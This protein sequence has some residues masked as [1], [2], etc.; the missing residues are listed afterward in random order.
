MIDVADI[1]TKISKAAGVLYALRDY[2]PE[3]SLRTLYYSI[4]YPHMS[5]H[6]LAWGKSP[7]T[8]LQPL[9][10][11]LN[12][13]IRSLSPA[14]FGERTRDIYNRLDLLNVDQLF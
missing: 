12:R 2:L 5:L 10:V 11:A 7:E 1:T 8:V 14:H 13:V 9:R 6:I 3:N 4:V